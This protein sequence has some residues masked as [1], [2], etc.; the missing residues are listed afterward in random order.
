MTKQVENNEKKI[1][2][3]SYRS[4]SIVLDSLDALVYVSDMEAYEVLLANAYGRSIWGDIRGQ[5]CWKVLQT[6]QDGPCSF[7]TNNRLLDETGAPAGVYVWEFQ[8][9]VNKRWYQC[10][11]LAIR[12][13]DGRL[14]RLEIATDITDRKAIE[15]ELL[16]AKKYAEEL[17]Q[18]DELTGL[19]NRRVFFERGHNILELAKRSGHSVSVIMMDIDHF[20]MTNDKYGHAVGDKVLQAVAEPLKR[21]VR[22]IDIV[23]RI[24]GEEFA[25]VLPE[26][27]L[28]DATIMAERLRAEIENLVVTNNE[29]QI[30]ITAS[31]GLVAC[32]DGNIGIDALLANADEALYIAKRNG[33]NQIKKYH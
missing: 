7:C 9:T 5:T 13:I 1:A 3:E 6:D 4:I 26:T 28:E 27:C 15:E 25:F 2:D 21:I 17:S 20:K 11:D 24:G 31:F 8:N 30:K 12:W 29:H 10:R 32:E 18:K 16:A 14:V 23:A 19:N 22:E 33:R